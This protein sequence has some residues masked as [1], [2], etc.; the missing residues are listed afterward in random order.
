MSADLPEIIESITASGLPWR[1]FFAPRLSNGHVY[2]APDGGRI[3]LKNE[4]YLHIMRHFG[5]V[6][7]TGEVAA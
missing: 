6:E 7:A 5:P 2:C 3:W 4:E 1:G